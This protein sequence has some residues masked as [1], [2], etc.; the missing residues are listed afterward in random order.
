MTNRITLLKLLTGCIECK[1]SDCPT[2]Q[3]YVCHSC[4]SIVEGCKIK[5]CVDMC[6]AWSCC[7]RLY[8]ICTDK[9]RPWIFH[10]TCAQHLVEMTPKITSAAIVEANRGNFSLYDAVQRV[11]ALVLIDEWFGLDSFRY[12]NRERFMIDV[13]LEM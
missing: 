11:E 9:D 6:E 4:K 8:N 5:C 13:D 1:R 12:N 3:E 10:P 7:K 2:I